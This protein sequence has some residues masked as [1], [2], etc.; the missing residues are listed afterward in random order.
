MSDL[1]LSKVSFTPEEV[2]KIEEA[3]N[4]LANIVRPKLI[5]LSPDDRKG[6]RRMGN[7]MTGFCENALAYGSRNPQFVPSY[8]NMEDALNLFNMVKSLM[9]YFEIMNS[10]T[11]MLNDTI[12]EAGNKVLQ[13]SSAIYDSIK[14]AA[15]NRQPGAQIIADELSEWFQR[16]SS[17]APQNEEPVKV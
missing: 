2:A 14:A 1:N 3:K 6:M 8:V 12:L 4:I 15:K 9:G 5:Q 7:K 16:A 13:D 10:T 11:E 17:A